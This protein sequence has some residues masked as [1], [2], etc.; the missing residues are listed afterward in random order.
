MPSFLSRM[1]NTTLD[2]DDLH[3]S[4]HHIISRIIDVTN[5]FITNVSS[6]YSDDQVM[7]DPQAHGFRATQP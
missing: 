6:G 3:Q 2:L 5:F 1:L 7:T 4:I